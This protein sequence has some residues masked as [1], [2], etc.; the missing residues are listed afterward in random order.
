MHSKKA[1]SSD[2]MSRPALIRY[3]QVAKIAAAGAVL[4]RAVSGNLRGTL[5]GGGVGAAAGT[6]WPR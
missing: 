1:P 5:I 3:L 2:R 6:V 4:G